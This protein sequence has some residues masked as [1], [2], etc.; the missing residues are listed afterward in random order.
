VDA[1]GRATGRDVSDAVFHFVYGVFK[2]AVVAQQI[3]ARHVRGLTSDPR[4]ARSTPWSRRSAGWRTGP[5]PSTASTG[6]GE[7]GRVRRAYAPRTR[8]GNPCDT[9]VY[10][11][12]Y[13][14]TQAVAVAIPR[15]ILM[16][17]ELSVRKT[18]VLTRLS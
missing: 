15:V 5:P 3:Y 4:F 1:Y 10:S 11:S 7:R 2:L 12:P 17:H 18:S 9:A 13:A 16:M 14:G 8:R 6:W